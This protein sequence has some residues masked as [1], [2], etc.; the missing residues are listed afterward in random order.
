MDQYQDYNTLQNVHH[1]GTDYVILMRKADARLV[2]MAPHGGGIEPGTVD[3]ADAIAG[4]DFTFYAFKGLMKSGNRVLHIGSSRF[5]E[6]VGLSVAGEAQIVVT[7]HGC[8]GKIPEILI[9]GS[10]AALKDTLRQSLS[11]AGFRA[12]ISEQPGLRG[13]DP[14]NICNR[15]TH[16]GGVQLELSRG[17]REAM[18]NHLENRSFRGKTTVFFDFV[19]A[20][21]RPLREQLDK[22]RAQNKRE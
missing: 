22:W 5:D 11:L 7:I 15:F 20:V 2:V 16:R 21:R 9:G 6:P 10:H 14:A 3:I 1:E 12:R 13:M 18:F 4:G 8:R 19:Q 17:Q